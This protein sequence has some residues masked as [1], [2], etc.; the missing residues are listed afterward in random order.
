MGPDTYMVSDDGGWASGTSMRGPL[1]QNADAFCLNQQKQML[2]INISS[3]DSDFGKYAS[4]E[5]DFRCLAVGDPE[6]RRPNMKPVPNIL[7]ENTTD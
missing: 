6:L 2:P 5:L 4:A 1:Y 3:E 7:I